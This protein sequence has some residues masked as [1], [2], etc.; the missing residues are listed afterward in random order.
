MGSGPGVQPASV[1]VPP[2][3]SSAVAEDAP[4]RR[5][6]SQQDLEL[7]TSSDLCQKLMSFIRELSESIRGKACSP[8]RS[9][10]A[11]PLIRG[12]VAMLDELERW[13]DEFP[14]LAQPMRF[15]NR[16]FRQW[17]AR[18]CERGEALLVEALK[19]APAAL[20]SPLA[21]ELAHYLRGAFGDESRIDYGTG[22]EAAFLAILF[23][24]GARGVLAKAD[25]ADS[26]LVVFVAYLRV[27]RRL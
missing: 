9:E 21:T 25:A 5:I 22:H 16:A 27:M 7:F 2:A 3:P 8:E 23:V 15:G 11:S 4:R 19:V 13:V 10:A 14:P 24:L 26:V 20:R 1:V 6:R 18:L 17:H 12:L